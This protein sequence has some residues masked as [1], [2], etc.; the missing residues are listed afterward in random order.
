MSVMMLPDAL[1]LPDSVMMP[2]DGS[3]LPDSVKQKF[4]GVLPDVRLLS[5]E[6]DAVPHPGRLPGFPVPDVRLAEQD[7]LL[8]PAVKDVILLLAVPGG[9]PALPPAV[10]NLA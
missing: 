8:F 3:P 9:P 5:A 7:V 1:Q 6:P 2:P 4:P 10:W